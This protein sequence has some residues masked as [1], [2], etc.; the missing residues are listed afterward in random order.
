MT[1]NS[2]CNVQITFNTLHQRI[3]IIAY[4]PF[5]EG[6]PHTRTGNYVSKAS[7]IWQLTPSTNCNVT[8]S[9]TNFVTGKACSPTFSHLRYNRV[10]YLY[11]ASNSLHQCTNLLCDFWPYNIILLDWSKCK[12]VHFCMTLTG[13]FINALKK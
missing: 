4:F 2:V 1:N 11:V 13:I 9:Q 3:L 8:D 5:R 6:S 10:C 12:K 7:P